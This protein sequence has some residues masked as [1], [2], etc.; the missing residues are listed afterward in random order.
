MPVRWL[1]N[2]SRT[3]VSRLQVELIGCLGRNKLHR[4][5]LHCL[6]DRFRIAEI[7]LLRAP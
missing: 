6:G 4:R 2:R 1:T 7:V 3:P 5:T